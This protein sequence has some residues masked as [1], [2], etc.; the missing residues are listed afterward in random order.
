ML[1]ESYLHTLNPYL[2]Q[3]SDGGFGIRWYGLAY[4]AGFVIAWML[5]KW[6]ART[7]RSLVA[8]AAVGDLMIYIIVGVLVGG[9]LGY[10]LFYDQSLFLGLTRDEAGNVVAP[11][12]SLLA[13]NRG[14]MASHG[15]M[16]GALLAAL[17]FMAR[18]RLFPVMHGADLIAFVAPP[19]LFLGR[20]ANFINGELW[21][22]PVANQSNPPWW[23]VK[24]PEEVFT[25]T[26]DVEPLRQVVP[27]QEMFLA[28][29]V[30][31]VRQGEPTVVN[32]VVPQ[33]TAYYPS[34]LFQAMAEGPILFLVLIAVW[35]VPRKAGVITG[36]FLLTYGVMRIITEIFRQPDEG[37]ALIMG[38]SRGQALSAIMILVGLLVIVLS[39]GSKGPRIGGLGGPGP[40]PAAA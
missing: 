20:L 1:A 15:G 35:W 12:W 5:I 22:H 11:W 32:V 25:G 16:I 9:R 30:E 2:V 31:A 28:N 7:N 26:I 37:V 13:I 33:L 10:A 18:R 29:V 4:V 23:S 39:A 27:G 40:Q 19:G 3:L 8:P 6:L 24:Y 38:L 34:Q 14:G 21:G 36:T 17:I